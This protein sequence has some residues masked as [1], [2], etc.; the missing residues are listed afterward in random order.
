[1]RGTSQRE[2]PRLRAPA[3]AAPGRRPYDEVVRLL[4]IRHGQTPSNVLRALD[5]GAPGPG[6]TEIGIQ[7]A[8]DLVASLAHEPIA[9]LF[10][11]NLHRAQL[12]AAPLAAALGLEVSVREGLREIAA[13]C[14]EMRS[15]AAS[16]VAY[17]DV[18]EA[19]MRGRHDAR[20]DGG[21]ACTEVYARFNAVIGEA[22]ALSAELGALG[23]GVAGRAVAIV[24]HGAMIRAWCGRHAVNVDPDF[25]AAQ[26]LANTGIV[27]L[28]GSSAEGWTVETWEGLRIV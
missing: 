14:L 20:L 2:R 3:S 5:T 1:M 12:T 8:A 7:Q 23:G 21:E 15:D 16:I 25:V 10:A 27:V 4:L 6:L 9:A 22:E 24:S 28:N 13:G 26:N 17:H 18:L 19:W 11:S